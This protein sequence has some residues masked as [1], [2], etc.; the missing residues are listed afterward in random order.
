MFDNP[1]V[2]I[3]FLIDKAGGVMALAAKAGVA[4]TTVLDWRKTGFIPGNRV[5]TISAALKV[6]VKDV[7]TLVQPPKPRDSVPSAVEAAE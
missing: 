7:L 1:A 2:D 5:A 3:Q 4:R 6:P